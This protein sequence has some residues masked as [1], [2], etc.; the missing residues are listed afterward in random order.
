MVLPFATRNMHGLHRFQAVFGLACA[1]S[2][3][4]LQLAQSCSL[5]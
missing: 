3:A 2:L 1:L 4:P 5:Q